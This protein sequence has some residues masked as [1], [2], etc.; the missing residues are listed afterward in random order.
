MEKFIRDGMVA[1]LFSPG[2]GA[3]W[4]T[5]NKEYPQILFDPIIVKLLLDGHPFRELKNYVET[6]YPGVYRGGLRDLMVRWIPEGIW[7]R[8]TEYDG[9]ENIVLYADESWHVA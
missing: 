8:V 3:G 4:Y 6:T 5:S 9:S 7:F 1:V 2:Y